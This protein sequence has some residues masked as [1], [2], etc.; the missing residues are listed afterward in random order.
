VHITNDVP[1]A[2][3]GGPYSGFKNVAFA[4]DGSGSSDGNGDALTYRWDFGDGTTGSGAHPSHTYAIPAGNASHV[5]TVSLVVSDGITDSAPAT[6]SAE[7]LDHAP[8]ADATGASTG[9]RNQPVT[10]DASGSPDED[11]DALTYRWDFGDGGTSTE[12]NPA[13][14]YAAFGG[15]TARLIVHDGHL[16]YAPAISGVTL[17]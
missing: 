14:A 13:H 4:L 3:A 12:R 9:F 10:F 6:A 11:G 1:L 15:Y 7:V 16:E 8:H 2:S 5:Y 17:G